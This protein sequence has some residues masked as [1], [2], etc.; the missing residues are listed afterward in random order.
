MGDGEAQRVDANL[1]LAGILY[2]AAPDESDDE[3]FGSLDDDQLRAEVELLLR[4]TFIGSSF[5]V[6][7][8]RFIDELEIGLG[9]TG[10]LLRCRPATRDA[11]ALGARMEVS[12]RGAKRGATWWLH[13]AL[14][15]GRFTYAAERRADEEDPSNTSVALSYQ[16]LS[17][18]LAQTD[19]TYLEVTLIGGGEL[20]L[21]FEWEGYL[22]V[23]REWHTV[24]DDDAHMLFFSLALK[25]RWPLWRPAS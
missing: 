17:L 24:A 9:A 16:D 14:E 20:P 8:D 6:G 19:Y 2:D 3:D 18:S 21:G 4:R 11:A 1:L 10:E 7:G 5:G 22:S 12:T 25:R 13:G 23:N 15:G